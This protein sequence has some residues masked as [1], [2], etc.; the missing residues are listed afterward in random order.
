MDSPASRRG[1]AFFLP[2]ILADSYG[3]GLAGGVLVVLFVNVEF[4]GLGIDESVHRVD[5]DRRN[6]FGFGFGQQPMKNGTDVGEGFARAGARSNDEVFAR[7]AQA[8]GFELMAVER[9]ALEDIGH[10]VVEQA[11]QAGLRN[12]FDAAGLLVGGIELKERIGPELAFR[13]R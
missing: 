12:V 3:K 6:T 11:E 10:R 4:V 9:V 7:Y 5:D 2:G 13:E 1:P 8:D